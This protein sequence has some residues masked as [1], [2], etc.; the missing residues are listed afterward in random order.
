MIHLV[1]PGSQELPF[2]AG[3]AYRHGEPPGRTVLKFVSAYDLTSNKA[4]VT[5]QECLEWI[6]S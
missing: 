5:C 6:H 1:D 2:C 3:M 4:D